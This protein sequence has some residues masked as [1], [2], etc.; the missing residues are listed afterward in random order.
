MRSLARLSRG[1]S[2]SAQNTAP[3]ESHI[4]LRDWVLSIL[5]VL[6]HLAPV[7]T[8]QPDA[9]PSAGWVA[10][11][12]PF[13]ALGSGLALP[14]RCRHPRAVAGFVLACYAGLAL[15]QGLVPPYAGWVLIWSLA[16]S[17]E[18]RRRSVALA[19]VTAAATSVLLVA[20]ELTRPGDGAL[21]LLVA[22][23]VLVLLAA[24]LVRSERSRV[25]AVGRRAAAEERLRI[26]RDLHDLVGHGLSTIAVQSS[27]A[28][29]ALRSGDETVAGTALSAVESSSRIALREMRQMLGVLMDVD[30]PGSSSDKPSRPDGGP[31]PAPGLDDLGPLLEN[32]RAGGVAVTL[33]QTGDWDSASPGVQ[34]VVYRVVQ[35]GLTNAVKH[36]PGSLVTVRLDAT[37]GAGR[38][39]VETTGTRPSTGRGSGS[40]GDGLGLDGLRTRVAALSGDFAC[41]P[42]DRGWLIEARVPLHQEGDR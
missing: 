15:V 40:H 12:A 16:T 3:G 26:A 31:R 29:M 7:R 37:D 1:A 38:V 33:E 34:L 4:G 25:E 36:A 10:G 9:D 19:S 17:G 35:E 41:G 20:A 24:V 13:L 22:I 21:A 2:G 32:V 5:V 28:R 14:W 6:A 18:D 27:T 42:T 11:V 23:T 30:D 39:S 8:G